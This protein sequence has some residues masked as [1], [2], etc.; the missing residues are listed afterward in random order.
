MFL[1][2]HRGNINGSNLKIE[3][4]TE[5]ID[6]A[7]Y[8][9]YDVEIDIRSIRGV[10][11]LGHQNPQYVI[12]YEWLKKRSDRLWIHCK[13]I[14]VLE[15][16]NSLDIMF[17]YFWHES[18]KVTLTSKNYIWTYPTKEIIKNSIVVMPEISKNDLGSCS[19]I[20]SDYIERFKTNE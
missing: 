16:F 2:S 13:N 12:A 18:D 19:G 10:L 1:I 8:S 7:L 4:S 11:L 14:E 3:N 5:Y 20:C 17:N 9:G 15:W 6:V